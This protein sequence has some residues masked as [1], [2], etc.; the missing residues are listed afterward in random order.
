MTSNKK[1]IMTELQRINERLKLIQ[2]ERQRLEELY[3][4]LTYDLVNEIEEE[5]VKTKKVLNNG[6]RW[7]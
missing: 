4:G 2:K 6:N 1:E 3:K 7:L 5:S